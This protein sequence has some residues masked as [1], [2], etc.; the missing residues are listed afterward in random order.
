MSNDALKKSKSF[1]EK[2]GLAVEDAKKKHGKDTDKFPIQ[3]VILEQIALNLA[4][5]ADFEL[6]KSVSKKH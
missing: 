3:L 5:L 1:Y 6:Q 2:T 4:A